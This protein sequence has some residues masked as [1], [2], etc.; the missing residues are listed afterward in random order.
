M[1]AVGR[2][3]LPARVIGLVGATDNMPSG[4]ATNPGDVVTALNGKTIEVLNTD[5]EGRLVLADLLCYAGRMDPKPAAVVD[6]ATLTGAIIV[7]LGHVAGGLFSNNAALGEEL[8]RSGDTTGDRLWPFPMW[9]A[10]GK[11]L[12]GDTADLRNTVEKRP[13]PA[14]SIFAAKFLEEFVDYPWAHLDIAGVAWTSEEVPYH[15]KGATGFGVR[16]LVDWLQGRAL[17]VE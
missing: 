15:P 3:A 4:K 14:G 6:L 11:R 5:A 17:G 16:L 1:E 2:L 9:K 13:S 8:E 7:S 12:K 10:F